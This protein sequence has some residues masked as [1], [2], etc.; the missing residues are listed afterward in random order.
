MNTQAPVGALIFR[1]QLSFI[2]QLSL[3]SLRDAGHRVQLY[4]YGKVPN[5][6]DGIE[7]I[8]AQTIMKVEPKRPFNS[9][10]KP[11]LVDRFRYL[12]LSRQP[13]TIWVDCDTYAREPLTPRDGYLFAWEDV[14]HIGAGVLALPADSPALKALLAE[15]EGH[16]QALFSGAKD[17]GSPK[18]PAH[19]TL[20]PFALTNALKASGEIERAFDR[21]VLY[22]FAFEDVPLLLRRGYDELQ[23]IMADTQSVHLYGRALRHHLMEIENGV[24]KRWCLLGKLLKKHDI[25]AKEARIPVS[26]ILDAGRPSGLGVTDRGLGDSLH[27]GDVR[28]PEP[29]QPVALPDGKAPSRTSPASV[30][31]PRPADADQ[32]GRML[33]L[34]CMKNE[35]PYIL[36]WIGY[37]LSIGVEHFLVYTN[38]CADGTD[39][40][41]DHLQTR[42]IVTRL[43]NPFE[44]GEKPQWVALNDAPAQPVFQRADRYICMDVDEYINIHTGDGTLAALIE[45]T[46]DPDLISFTWR[47]YGC[48][49]VV[50]FEDRP[51]T[52]LFTRAAPEYTRKPHHNWGF[53]TM[54]RLPLPFERLG[55]HRP[56]RLRS[57]ADRPRWVNGSGLP[58]PP[59]YID[60]G[61]RST[62][63]SWGY[64]LATLNH[65]AVRSIESFLV[66]RDRGRVNHI[67]RDQGLEYWQIFNRND[68]EAN[69]ILPAA[70][71][72]EAITRLFKS[73]PVLADLHAQ[74]VDW[75]RAKIAELMTR[76]EFRDLYDQLSADPMAHDLGIRG[77]DGGTALIPDKK[78]G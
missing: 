18:P 37:H 26:L 50:G 27:V 29:E 42:G 43:D 44:T 59:N 78:T 1:G 35:G 38:D 12:L 49:G 9:T 2:E 66:K 5:V 77:E 60:D 54:A 53:K 55:V 33:I 71:R 6:P 47:F 48:G 46:G 14:E 68:E 30:V 67:S 32:L 25:D 31:T 3:T 74:S 65:Y 72:A 57:D 36:D 69:S 45:A 34:T 23:N 61:W 75:H 22:P 63:L 56:S 64:G 15:T 19:D 13:G 73:D 70:R 58:M 10:V 21:H 16:E 52:E 4:H 28:P 17:A 51:V 41:L 8:S 11:V 76:P 40:I 7:C 20:G 24:P 62:K 39:E